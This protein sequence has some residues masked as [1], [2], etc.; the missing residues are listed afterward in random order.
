MIHDLEFFKDC[1]RDALREIVR[2]EGLG[3]LTQARRVAT[4]CAGA[5]TECDRALAGAREAPPLCARCK[6]V[7]WTFEEGQ[8]VGIRCP[9]CNPAPPAAAL[10]AVD[11][12]SPAT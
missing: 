6:G 1:F 12:S 10:E 7:Q 5:A 2:A 3:V 8:A 11:R 4:L 9:A